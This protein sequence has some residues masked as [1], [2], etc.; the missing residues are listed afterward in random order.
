LAESW[1]QDGAERMWSV[2][3]VRV[4]DQIADVL[5]LWYERM[6]PRERFIPFVGRELVVVFRLLMTDEQVPPKSI[7]EAQRIRRGG[8]DYHI[9]Y[10]VSRYSRTSPPYVS[11]H[12]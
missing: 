2:I 1:A 10:S 5:G 4:P 11:H 6:I 8:R 12:I 3:E 9:R 7:H